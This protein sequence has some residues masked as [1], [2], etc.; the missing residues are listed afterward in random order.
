M[1]GR[2]RK[3]RARRRLELPTQ[4]GDQGRAWSKERALESVRE[5]GRRESLFHP[6]LVF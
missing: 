3:R 5:E 1:K 2:Q 4:G 6:S